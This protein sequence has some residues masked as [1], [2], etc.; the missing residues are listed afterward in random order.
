MIH[1][2]IENKGFVK[3]WSIQFKTKR[4]KKFSYCILFDSRENAK[5]F[6]EQVGNC[7]IDEVIDKVVYL[8]RQYR[9]LTKMN[10]IYIA[11]KGQSVLNIL[12]KM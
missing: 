5:A 4:G 11:D 7:Y 9:P 8:N 12:S 10:K 3:Y 1:K 6:A 2:T